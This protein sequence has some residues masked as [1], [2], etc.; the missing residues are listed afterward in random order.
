MSLRRCL[1]QFA[2]IAAVAVLVGVASPAANAQSLWGGDAEWGGAKQMVSFGQQYN[3]GQII[4]SFGDRRLL[5]RRSPRQG[6]ELPDRRA[7][8]AEPLGRFD[9]G[10][11]EAREPVVDGRRLK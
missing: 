10:D 5:S 6:H 4:V 9:R 8:R 2:S 3:P 11:A 1:K 7:A